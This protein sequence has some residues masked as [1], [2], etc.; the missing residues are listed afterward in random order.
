MVPDNSTLI[1]W[2][3]H[4]RAPGTA[5]TGYATCSLCSGVSISIPAMINE[6][7]IGLATP[8]HSTPGEHT[9]RRWGRFNERLRSLVIFPSRPATNDQHYLW[10]LWP[11]IP[12]DIISTMSSFPPHR[13]NTT[14]LCDS[15]TETSPNCTAEIWD[16]NRI[17]SGNVGRSSSSLETKQLYD[18][19]ATV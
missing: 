3:K 9:L 6:L 17:M 4:C 8:F 15:A 13:I 11:S 2:L 10:S 1:W 14:Y 5:D 19:F 18:L 7:S 12:R 16:A